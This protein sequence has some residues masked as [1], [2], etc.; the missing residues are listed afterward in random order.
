MNKTHPVSGRLFGSRPFTQQTSPTL[1][2]PVILLGY[3]S[4]LIR[5]EVCP[6]RLSVPLCRLCFTMAHL[7]P[8]FATLLHDTGVVDAFQQ[9]LVANTMTD[10]TR[11][12]AGAP[13]SVDAELITEFT[14]GGGTCLE[15]PLCSTH[16][17]CFHFLAWWSEAVWP[18]KLVWWSEGVWPHSWFEV[19]ENEE[20][21]IHQTCPPLTWCWLV[22]FII[23][24]DSVHPILLPLRWMNPKM[25]ISTMKIIGSI[26][27]GV[28]T[29]SPPCLFNGR[30]GLVMHT[31]IAPRRRRS[32][33]RRFHHI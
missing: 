26:K 19:R 23:R 14:T 6:D 12:L 25:V 16:L 2:P 29:I 15:H 22:D 17:D 10:R 30:I 5:V 33:C 21:T 32:H 8:S 13:T 7:E 3:Q 24:C 18:H 31:I 9:W 1:H 28:V 4:Q 11:F 27:H 20:L